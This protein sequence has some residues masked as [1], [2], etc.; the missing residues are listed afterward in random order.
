MKIFVVE[1]AAVE[2]DPKDPL[3]PYLF[4]SIPNIQDIKPRKAPTIL[5]SRLVKLDMSFLPKPK[6]DF[7]AEPDSEIPLILN[8][9]PA[10]EFSALI[11]KIEKNRSGSYSWYGK[12]E[13]VPMSQVILVVKGNAVYGNILKL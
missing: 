7:I 6:E 2:Q 12:L 3:L 13:N 1:V 9:F 11:Y 4:L 8:F 5:R 10:T